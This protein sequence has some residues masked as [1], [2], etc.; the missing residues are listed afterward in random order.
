MVKV[1]RNK[2]TNK[3]MVMDRGERFHFDTKA[4][5]MK[6]AK[7][8]RRNADRREFNATLSMIT[9]TSARAARLDMGL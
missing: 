4:E 5:A 9:G 3:F 7:A 8:L 6:K 2:L 1:Y